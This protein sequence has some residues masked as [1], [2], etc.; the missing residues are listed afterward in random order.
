MSTARAK[1][2]YRMEHLFSYGAT[3]RAPPEVIGPVPEGLRVNFHI[4]GGTVH[5][6]RLNGILRPVG[7]DSFLL[8]R[9][10]VGLLDVRG[11]IE[12]SDGGLI[13]VFYR[14]I[15]DLGED[16]YDR[17]LRG[18]LPKKLAL[19][20]GPQLRTAHPA[21]QWLQRL[22]C[23]GVGEVDFERSEVFYD[24]YAVN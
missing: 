9:D 24:V 4:T 14:G 6:E 19:R 8:R 3:L 23:V 12:A 20:T 11:T 21:H 22:H 13:D 18:D 7:L 5:G 2:D 10:G 1:F 17:F 15:G 16:G